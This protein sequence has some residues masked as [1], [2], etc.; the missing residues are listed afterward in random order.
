MANYIYVLRVF[1]GVP[2]EPAEE[3]YYYQSLE[4]AKA[5]FRGLLSNY[6]EGYELTLTAEP[7]GIT[8]DRGTLLAEAVLEA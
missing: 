5:D 3:V 1:N 2:Y 7:T 6:P 8:K 4:E